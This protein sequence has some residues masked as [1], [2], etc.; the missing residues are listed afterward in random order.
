MAAGADGD[1]SAGVDRRTVD[2]GVAVALLVVG[3]IELLLHADDG[4]HGTASAL[5]SAL[6]LAPL[7][8]TLAGRRSWPWASFLLASVAIVVPGLVIDRSLPFYGGLLVY[9]FSTYSASRFAQ[10]RAAMAVPAVVA[11]AYALLVLGTPA[12]AEIGQVVFLLV[13]FGLAWAGGQAVRRWSTT[14]TELHAEL[15]E[16]SVRND[17]QARAAVAEERASIARELHDIVAHSVSVMVVQA[18]SA[19]LELRPE[20]VA[21][22]TALESVEGTGRQALVEMRRLLGVLRADTA[23]PALAPTPSFDQLDSLLDAMRLSGLAVTLQVE[24]RRRPLDP[25]VSLAAYRIVQESL[26][27]ALKHAGAT[28][29]RVSLG[30]RED[31]LRIV[32]DNDAGPASR[33]VTRSDAGHGL[34]GMRERVAMLGGE[35]LV[36]PTERGGFRVC[37][38]LPLAP[39]QVVHAT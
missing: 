27:N 9:A 39:A 3:Q 38:T 8:L 4:Y 24:G 35:L 33:G 30:F 23:A 2:V 12:F 10:P 6:A 15:A 31:G 19:R 18:T 5:A 13:A 11:V 1:A 16:V 29:A 25:G 26:T 22:R 7:P 37:A 28:A 14:A 20:Q 21:A 17:E 36:G 32:V 34:I